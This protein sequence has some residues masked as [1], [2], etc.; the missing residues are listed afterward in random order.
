VFVELSFDC[1]EPE[2]FFISDREMCDTYIVSVQTRQIRDGLE[3]MES[4][5]NVWEKLV[6][7][8]LNLSF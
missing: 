7:L 6:R 2:V 8:S 3:A 4:S 1:S 5:M